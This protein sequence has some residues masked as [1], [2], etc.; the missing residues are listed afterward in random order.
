MRVILVDDERLALDYLERQLMKLDEVVILG[1][2]TN[3]FEAKEQILQ[4]DVDVI[5]LDISLPEIN[6]IELAEQI[7]EKKPDMHIVFVTAY[8]EHAVK[9]F[10]L[11]ALDYIVKPI[12]AERLAITMERVKSRRVLASKQ[13]EVPRKEEHIRLNVL[14]QVTIETSPGQFSIMQWRTSKAQELFLYLLQHRGQLVRKSALIDLL[15]PEYEM[16]KVYSQLYT[17]VYHIRKTLEP[18]GERFQIANATEGYILKIQ[19]V[20]L[21]VEQWESQLA[22]LFPPTLERVDR[23]SE[24]IKQYTGHYLQEH[25]YWW[26][27]SERQRLKELW[28]E[29][30]Y[31]VAALYERAGLLDQAIN[32]YSAICRQHALEEEAYFALM[33]IHHSMNHPHLVEREYDMLTRIYQEELN[34]EPSP[35]IIKWFKQNMIE[36]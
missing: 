10:E 17:A 25:D 33:K 3:P 29:A 9:A 13:Q 32:S 26:A 1:K 34:E 6:G 14:R 5:F 4:Q 27:E 23:C 2:Y 28:L 8:N 19:N 21:D 12:I 7:L 11:N 24:A 16:D 31:A 22:S 18:F 20:V 15:W 35:H 36:Q 30:S